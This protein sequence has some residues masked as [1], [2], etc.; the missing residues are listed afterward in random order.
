MYSNGYI[1]TQ[2]QTQVQTPRIVWASTH[3]YYHTYVLTV[4]I[5]YMFCIL[6]SGDY[7][8]QHYTDD[9]IKMCSDALTCLNDVAENLKEEMTTVKELITLTSNLTQVENL[10]CPEVV[11]RVSNDSAFNVTDIIAQRTLDVMKFKSYC[12]KVK[13]LFQYCERI[14]NGMN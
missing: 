12:S 11:K 9:C 13:I 6:A 1:H 4:F 7:L 2:A 14:S 8:A 3:V 5:C 10:F